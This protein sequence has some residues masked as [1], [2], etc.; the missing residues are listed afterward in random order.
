[1]TENTNEVDDF[2]VK[3]WLFKILQHWYYFIIVAG[4]FLSAAHIYLRYTQ[5]TYEVSASLI[6]SEDTSSAGLTNGLFTG[7]IGRGGSSSFQ[8]VEREVAILTSFEIVRETL[9]SLNFQVSYFKDGK[10]KER[11]ILSESPIDIKLTPGYLQ[12]V[13]K[14]YFS[15]D[16]YETYTVVLGSLEEENS[17]SFNCFFGKPCESETFSFVTQ[18]LDSSNIIKYQEPLYA[19]F[20]ELDRLT[21]SYIR[22]IRAG[23]R[24]EANRFLPGQIIDLSIDGEL[25]EKNTIFLN[26]L[27]RIFINYTLKEKNKQANNTIKFIDTQLS[28]IADSLKIAESALEEFRLNKGMIDLS[29]TGERVLTQLIN[30]ENQKSAIELNQKYYSYLLEYL[31][32]KSDSGNEEVI[33][34]TSVG[35]TDPTLAGLIVELN[36][37]ISGKILLDITAGKSN[38]AL[39]GNSEQITS[40][41]NR[42]M[43]NVRNI[44]ANNALTMAQIDGNIATL[45]LEIGELPGNERALLTIQ[46]KFNIN[47]ELY[48]FLLKQKS[49]SEIKRAA[50][51]ANIKILEKSRDIQA[52]LIGPQTIRIYL[53]ALLASFSLVLAIV[54]TRLFFND[55]LT[56]ISQLKQHSKVSFLADVPNI[57]NLQSDNI[58]V[59]ESPRGRLA[60]AFRS[61]RI[62][63]DYVI[64]ANEGVGR[65]VGLTS[66]TSGEG[67]TFCSINLA[68]ILAL[69]GKKTLLIGLDLRKPRIQKELNLTDDKGLSNFLI[70][71]ATK[72]EI[73][74]TT[75]NHFL[76][77]ITSGPIP[78]NP[79]ELIENGRLEGLLNAAKKD[80]DYIIIDGPPI[81]LVT[82]YIAAS[83]LIQTTLFVLRINYSPLQSYKVL[84]DYVDKDILK[85]SHVIVNGVLDKGSKKY[86]YGYYTEDKADS[87]TFFS[88]LFKRKRT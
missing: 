37:L 5:N 56:D 12:T 84:L 46:R 3:Y 59:K 26:A 38:F 53:V 13:E 27:S 15:F 72:E 55:K 50:N 82:D 87:G 51:S 71:A 78:P 61:L 21:V 52:K 45:K 17:E 42:L 57:K 14:L 4:L 7:G 86:G 35:I 33:S 65:V 1:M 22:R 20:K 2:D 81:G 43:E 83:P 32:G 74:Q 58:S 70:N 24:L 16:G 68:Y 48:T 25:V 6:L 63:L 76:D 19:Q 18:I 36:Q 8:S 64:P 40:V 47:N 10:I 23:D 73:I 9:D 44:L 28:S 29:S 31:K 67:K 77:V 49:E 34:P 79:T 88:K 11:E 39:R 54:L 85:S 75:N 80:Y 60:E 41:K 69:T 66:A 30:L 62:N